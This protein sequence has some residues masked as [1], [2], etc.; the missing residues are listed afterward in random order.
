[1]G[2]NTLAFVYRQNIKGMK[3]TRIVLLAILLTAG[4]YAGKAQGLDYVQNE[5]CENALAK[6]I[7]LKYFTSKIES[8][9][10]GLKAVVGCGFDEVDYFVLVG[11]Q[12]MFPNLAFDMVA[13]AM[14][15]RNQDDSITY[16]D[17]REAYDNYIIN[18]NSDSLRKTASDFISFSKEKASTEHWESTL[19]ALK[20]FNFTDSDVIT[21][22][23]LSGFW[24]KNRS[25][26]YTFGEIINDIYSKKRKY[27]LDVGGAENNETPD[28]P[29]AQ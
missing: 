3:F 9:N 7:D 21:I 27:I 23:T 14:K 12:E 5:K 2:K 24:E 28:S 26:G 17:L 25:R 6:E 16:Y 29:V 20:S 13:E 19:A 10:Q 18:H 1:M 15:L 22:R 11:P 8:F 4:G